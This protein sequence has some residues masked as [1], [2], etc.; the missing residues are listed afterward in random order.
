MFL[1]GVAKLRQAA[2]ANGP[3]C[4]TC[5]VQTCWATMTGVPF[6][7][8]VSHGLQAGH[9]GEERR[10]AHRASLNTFSPAFTR[11]G[12]LM[13]SFLALAAFPLPRN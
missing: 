2:A 13:R 3:L 11:S 6:R 7:A 8:F 5:W 12:T 10:A 4:S 9:H 1:Y